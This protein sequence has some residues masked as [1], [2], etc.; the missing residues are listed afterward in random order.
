MKHQEC[1]SL[2]TMCVFQDTTSENL[3]NGGEKT[4]EN[5]QAKY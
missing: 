5:L 3:Y 2:V 1:A 4:M